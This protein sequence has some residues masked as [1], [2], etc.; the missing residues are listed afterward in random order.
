MV[1]EIL[2]AL[3]LLA[4]ACHA[5]VFQ[6]TAP[7]SD[8]PGT[9]REAISAANESPDLDEVRKSPFSPFYSRV[10]RAKWKR[11]LLSS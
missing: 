1:S 8:G 4:C 6:V 7:D 9:L 10:V 3:L 2:V 5:A 11:G